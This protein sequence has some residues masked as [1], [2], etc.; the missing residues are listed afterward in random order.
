MMAHQIEIFS[1][2]SGKAFP[3][4]EV[5]DELFSAGLM[6]PGL[7]IML[8]GSDWNIYAPLDAVCSAVFP[9]GHAVALK[10]A[11]GLELLIHIGIE[12]FRA[13]GAFQKNVVE[14]QKVSRGQKLIGID[15]AFFPTQNPL[16]IFTLIN[17]V[18]F[19]FEPHLKEMVLAGK[20]TLFTIS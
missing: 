3:L 20:T 19:S 4:E 16:V 5:P 6:G 8:D 14:D 9:T 1:P 12:T 13:E 7:A 10:H 18:Q 17:G 2:A 11:G 15:P